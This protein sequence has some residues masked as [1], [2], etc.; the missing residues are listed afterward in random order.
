[1]TTPPSL[2]GRRAEG[3]LDQREARGRDWTRRVTHGAL[4]D[5]E[6]EEDEAR[7]RELAGRLGHD[8][9]EEERVSGSEVEEAGRRAQ[10]EP[11]LVDGARGI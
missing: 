11:E 7:D 4:Q 10:D 6:E 1:M 8:V 2:G 3:E 9:L 5:A